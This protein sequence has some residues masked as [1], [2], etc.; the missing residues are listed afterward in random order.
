[1]TP[2]TYLLNQAPMITRYLRLA[3]WP[4]GLVVAYGPPLPI[5]F[6]DALPYAVMVTALLGATLVALV[7]WPLVGFA[8][9]W[10]FL[11]LAPT[12]SIVPIATEVGAER[13]MYLPLI[14]LVVLAVLALSSL[15]DRIAAQR[16]GRLLIAATAAISMALAAASFERTREYASPLGLATTVLQ[17]W[18]TSFAHALVGTQLAVE[19]RHDSAIAE[20]RL[21]A[22]GYAAAHYHLGGELFNQGRIDEAL[23]ELQEF[24]RLESWKAEAI[25]AR[26]MI[27][28]A[29]M[30]GKRW[31]EAAEELQLVL[32]MT[33][34][35]SDAHAIALGYLADTIL[36]EERF[37]E[38]IAY[39][40]AFLALRPSD[41]GGVINLGIALAQTGRSREAADAFRRALQIDPANI[42]ARRNLELVEEEMRDRRSPSP[43]LSR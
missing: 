23:P 22:P 34:P 19:G 4:Q 30:I 41:P 38:A 18:P 8:G 13:R 3:I 9:A 1:V 33:N 25:P 28:R 39:Y 31:P 29:F 15:A 2:W 24:V 35:A 6:A 37:D 20:L 26:T 17:R 40:R 32:T 27:G 7:R 10:V 12:S 14:A 21:A 43:P 16:P 42:N 36:N 11:T 5:T